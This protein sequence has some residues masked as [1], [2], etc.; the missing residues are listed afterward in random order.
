MV[1]G[2]A[3]ALLLATAVVVVLILLVGGGTPYRVTARFQNA[4]LLV[5]GSLVTVAGEKVGTVEGL[6]LTDNGQAA[7]TLKIDDAYAPLRHGTRAVIRKH[8]LSGEANDYVDLQLGPAQGASLPRHATIPTIDTE[9]DVPLDAVLDVFDPVARTAVSKTIDLLRDSTHGRERRANAALRYLDPALSASARLLGELGRDRPDLERFVTAT[10]GLTTDLSARDDALAGV[11]SGLS[12]TMRAVATQRD[13]LGTAVDELPAFLRRASTTFAGLRTTLDRLDPL[14]TA[15]TPVVR[16]D[17]QPLLTGLRAFAPAA[18][19]VVRDLARA[20]RLPGA[21]NDLVELLRRQPAVD[22]IANR[23]AERNGAQRPGAFPITQR[24]LRG[25]TPQI[26]F[27]RPYSVDAVGWFDD[28]SSS[29][30]YDAL[31]SF[32]RAGLGLNQFSLTPTLNTL[33]PIPAALRPLLSTGLATGRNNRCPGS[34]ERPAADG[35]NPFVPSK[36]FNCDRTQV[37]LGP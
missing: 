5:K 4:G 33:L 25:A 1:R 2:V 31:G 13:A 10:A 3:V 22:R 37:P 19:P 6:R 30:A 24:A 16:R 12:R 21:D 14:V 26:A 34:D 32:S 20:I 28:Y 17:L 18:R 23:T 11:V 7:A 8:S 9:S 29:G 15:A 36:D 35:S 27:A